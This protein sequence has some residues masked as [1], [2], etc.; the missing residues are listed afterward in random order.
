MVSRGWQA[1]DPRYRVGGGGCPDARLNLF[2]DLVNF[3]VNSGH[4]HTG[5]N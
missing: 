2:C 4:I 3:S 1:V 5:R